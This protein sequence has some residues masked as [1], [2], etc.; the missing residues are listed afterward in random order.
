MCGFQK[1]TTLFV[2]WW[3]CLPKC[4]LTCPKSCSASAKLSCVQQHVCTFCHFFP[5]N[6]PYSFHP[7]VSL[8]REKWQ[9]VSSA[10]FLPLLP[11]ALTFVLTS[12]WIPDLINWFCQGISCAS[13]WS[14]NNYTASQMLSCFWYSF[15][16]PLRLTVNP[17]YTQ[18]QHPP[19]KKNLGLLP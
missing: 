2:I 19:Q 18:K 14:Q 4:R 8:S 6:F 16:P 3:F 17:L 1:T 5:P 10:L 7:K 13:C 15:C 11:P 9:S 12:V